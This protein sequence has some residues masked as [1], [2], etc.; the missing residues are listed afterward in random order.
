MSMEVDSQGRQILWVW[1]MKLGEIDIKRT[2]R[3]DEDSVRN[4]ALATT[5]CGKTMLRL[6]SAEIAEQHKRPRTFSLS[7]HST[8]NP[9]STILDPLEL[10]NSLAAHEVPAHEFFLFL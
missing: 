7:I 4:L 5:P 10:L 3:S 6:L 8:G 2:V 9:D 1:Q